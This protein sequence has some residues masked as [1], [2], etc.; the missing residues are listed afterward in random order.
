[1]EELAANYFNLTII[2]GALPSVLRG[3]LVT[4]EVALA[5]I[6]IGVGLG[7]GLALLRLPGWKLVHGLITAW[8]ELFRTLPQLVILIFLYFALPYAGIRLSP[9]AATALALGAVLSAFA[10]EIFTAAIMALPKGQWEAAQSLGFGPIR[11]LWYIIL[12]Q[13]VRLATPLV[14]NRIIAV[15]KGSALGVAVSLDDT[16]G[17]AQS[18]MSITANPSP[19][20]LAAALYLVFFIPLVALSRLIERRMTLK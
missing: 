3:F 1:M 11:T 13:S 5:V 12:P 19:L 20:M 14:T 6:V 17:A 8:I 7:L 9:F 10:A 15:T 2:A 16:L 18:Y 4:V